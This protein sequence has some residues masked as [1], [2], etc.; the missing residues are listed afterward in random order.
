M[1]FMKP[2]APEKSEE[3]I[4]AEKRASAESERLDAET[5]KRTQAAY[6]ARRGRSS[7]LAEAES[8]VKS[9]LG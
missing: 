6:R 9:T 8:G 2:K 5:A 4:A 7:L 3:Q 1:G